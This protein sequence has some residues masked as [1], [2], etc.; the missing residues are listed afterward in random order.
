[1]RVF[2]TGATGFIGTAVVRELI[3]AGHQV[4]GLA[5]SD[6][7]ADT[8]KVAGAE[9]HRG[10]LDDL[11]SLRSGASAA[12]GV[13]HLAF[14][15]DFSEFDKA[16]AD[17]LRAVKTMGEVLE[18]TGKPF[19]ITSG[20]LMLTYVLPP[21]QIGT[22][23]DV[24]DNSVPRGE[25][26]NVVIS[27]A[28]RGVRSSF[29]RLPPSVHGLGDHGFVSSLIGIARD[30]GV[31][32]YIGDGYNRWPAVHRL[33]AARLFRLAVEAA[34]GGS[35]LHGVA[36]EGVPFRDIA[37][38]IGRHLNLPVVSISRE[39]ADAHFGWL[40]AF[41]PTDNPTSSALTQERLGWQPV[42]PKLI[43]D[44]EKGHYFSN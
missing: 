39:E 43:P 3:E 44:L 41:A 21:G 35:R 25:A 42:H 34:P 31:S 26:E 15:H 22:E 13:I 11:D 17:D 38:V 10:S 19:V 29:L 1:M 6:K 2:V 14:K 37:G 40:G 28:E 20:T 30:K 9:V 5:R 27:L 7:S 18:G 23:K 16:V 12:D 8:L 24:V 4:V 33:D 32:A 36:D